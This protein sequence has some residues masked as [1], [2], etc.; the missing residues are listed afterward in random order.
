MA[1][2]PSGATFVSES[3]IRTR[4]EVDRLAAAGVGA[5]LIGETLMRAQDPAAKVRELIGSP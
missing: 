3:G 1:D 4:E 2:C 5:V